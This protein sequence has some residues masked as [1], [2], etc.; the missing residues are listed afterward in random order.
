[1]I[2]PKDYRDR[3]KHMFRYKE[4]DSGYLDRLDIDALEF[5]KCVE[6]AIETEVPEADIELVIKKISSL[7]TEN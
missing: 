4:N 5:I 2:Q 3:I 1:M 6:L 7:I